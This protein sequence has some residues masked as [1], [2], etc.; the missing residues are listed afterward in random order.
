M[1]EACPRFRRLALIGVGLIG[2]SLARAV[3]EAH[4][5]DEIVG[6]P[7]PGASLAAARARGV[8]DREVADLR[9]AV[10]GAD[11]VV[12]ATPAGT[13]P[14]LLARLADCVAADACVTDVA[15][16]KGAIVQAAARLGVRQSRFCPGH[17]IAGAERSGV[18]AADAA[19]FRGRTVVLTPLP[20][21]EPAVTAR[22]QALWE[23]VGASVQRLDPA[24]H[25]ALLA[26][27]SHLPHLA[28]FAAIR[29][30]ADANGRF[31]AALAPFVGPGLC[32]FSRIAG[33]D[34]V[35][36]RDICL[37]NPQPLQRVLARLRSDLQALEGFI[38]SADGVALE[39]FFDAARKLRRE[40]PCT[41]TRTGP[42][43]S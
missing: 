29:Q 22:L 2:G 39:R 11:L 10:E 33:S 38:A 31:D 1:P 23:A 43:S 42:G 36:W 35:M 24:Q 34:A 19:L 16:V 3:R 20:Q 6:V 7:R 41:P 32:D 17:P 14:E 15:S 13:I 28:A 37:Q 25:D 12:L 4:L 21:T 5:V 27:T 18:E 30:C 40:A 8:I 26:V 9:V